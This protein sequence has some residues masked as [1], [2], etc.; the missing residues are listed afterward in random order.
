MS[1]LIVTHFAP[2]LDAIGAI[3]LLKQFDSQDYADAKVSFANPGETISN[4]QVQEMGFELH[5]VTHVDI[6]L[7]KFDHHQPERG[8]LKICATSLVFD[9]LCQKYPAT[10]DNQALR[11]IV[12]HI[13]EID[14]FEQIHWPDAAHLRYVFMIDNLISG[15]EQSE[16]QNDEIVV[17][18]GI[19]CLDAAYHSMTQIIQANQLIEAE[20]I[21]FNITAGACLAIETSNEEVINQAQKQGY[22]LVVR[23]DPEKGH[24]RI[25]VRP[26]TNFTLKE[27]YQAVKTADES[28]SWYYHPGGK[29][30]LNGSLKKRNQTPSPLS[31]AQITKLI[32]EVLG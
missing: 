14:H 30:L 22:L 3:W 12:R 17:E 11:E 32:K 31:L 8:G 5:N 25:K 4:T 24:V 16:P 29:M 21:Q 20:G 1:K 2:D 23:K 28:G 7:G 27:L 15:Y 13:T 26:D 10:K 6:G 18:F 19:K 9:H